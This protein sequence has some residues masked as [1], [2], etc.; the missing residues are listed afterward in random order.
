MALPEFSKKPAVDREPMRGETAILLGPYG[1]KGT[2][3]IVTIA[4]RSR[5]AVGLY[6][7]VRFEDGT[8]EIQR[9]PWFAELSKFNLCLT[10]RGGA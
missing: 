5:D 9:N 10:L 1:L 3:R 7:V 2:P 6:T 4:D 8:T